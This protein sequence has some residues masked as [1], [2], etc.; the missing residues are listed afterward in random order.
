MK[1]NSKFFGIVRIDTG[2]TH[3]WEIKIKRRGKWT[4]EMFSDSTYGGVKQS[5][6]ET[7]KRRDE[8]LKTIIEP[9]F[10]RHENASRIT[11]SNTSGIVGVR[12]RMAV[13]KRGDKRWEYEVWE[14]GGS[15][16]PGKQKMK[17]F[18][19]NT[20]GEDDAKALA[21]EQRRQW[22][23]EMKEYDRRMKQNK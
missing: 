6:S 18:Y 4:C 13:T 3:G 5:L 9:K 15:P 19:I 17:R 14:A 22:E 8:L 21:I 20:W 16:Q 11:K 12:R 2:R 7:M 10:E 23:E 1:T